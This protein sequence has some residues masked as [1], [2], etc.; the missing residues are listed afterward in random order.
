[1]SVQIGDKVRIVDDTSSHEIPEG[2][3]VV[4]THI[5]GL[6]SVV[7]DWESGRCLARE[8]YELIPEDQTLELIANLTW[9][10][11]RLTKRISALESAAKKPINVSV[12]LGDDTPYNFTVM[13]GGADA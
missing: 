5:G 7:V 13:R 12:K 3:K 10:V 2:T 4:V 11:I 1:M 6:G 8:D 9:E